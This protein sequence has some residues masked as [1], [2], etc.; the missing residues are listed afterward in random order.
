MD[1]S[2]R[3]LDD[4]IGARNIGSAVGVG[5]EQAAINISNQEPNRFEVAMNDL[6]LN[7]ETTDDVVNIVPSDGETEVSLD[8]TDSGSSGTYTG[9]TGGG[10]P[11][12]TGTY[13]PSTTSTIQART[14]VPNNPT[15]SDNISTNTN[16]LSTPSE[17]SPIEIPTDESNNNTTIEDTTITEEPTIDSPTTEP[18][19]N[20][21]SGDITITEEPTIETPTITNP[22]ESS[23]NNPVLDNI[24]NI[25]PNNNQPSNGGNYTGSVT[26]GLDSF[27]DGQG[28]KGELSYENKP[29]VEIEQ[30]PSLGDLTSEDNELDVISVGNTGT[31]KSGGSVIPAILGTGVAAA[32]GAAGI[33]YIKNKKDQNSQENEYDDE[34]DYDNTTDNSSQ[35]LGLEET[36]DDYQISNEI[37]TETPKYKAGTINKLVLDDGENVKINEDASIIAPKNSELE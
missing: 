31:D 13:G 14:E 30:T 8:T 34:N 17:T 21:M 7:Y 12:N 15:I 24:T 1:A 29:G 5:T 6:D 23:S 4:N 33:H 26:N 37:Q 22:G 32:A 18:N 2:Y 16:D 28:D 20:N 36:E 19:D 9:N 27:L 35:E 11:V 25:R 3:V 10:S